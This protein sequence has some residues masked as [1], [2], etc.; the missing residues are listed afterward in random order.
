MSQSKSRRELRKSL[1]TEYR[2]QF[3]KGGARAFRIWVSEWN[4]GAEVRPRSPWA[5]AWWTQVRYAKRRWLFGAFEPYRAVGDAIDNLRAGLD[6]YLR[7]GQPPPQWSR[8]S[9][10]FALLGVAMGGLVALI[11]AIAQPVLALTYVGW[12]SVDVAGKFA[13]SGFTAGIAFIAI[14]IV[15][16]TRTKFAAASQAE[17]VAG[18]PVILLRSLAVLGWY[19]G[20][21]FLCLVVLTFDQ[22]GLD[23]AAGH[24][25]IRHLYGSTEIS[26]AEYSRQVAYRL[27]AWSAWSLALGTYLVS[28]SLR[29][30]VGR[31]QPGPDPRPA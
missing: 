8:P 11:G 21:A 12:L 15:I 26:S 3:I 13:V 14:W 4:I 9:T 1:E 22:K 29:P 20:L 28:M 6:Q 18:T 30:F 24:F 25:Y 17:M 10:P 5:P 23:A 27:W 19:A 31:W 16:G 7:A 2:G